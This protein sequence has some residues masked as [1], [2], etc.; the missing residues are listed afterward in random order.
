[1][2]LVPCGNQARMMISSP[3]SFVIPKSQWVEQLLP[4]LGYG[5]LQVIEVKIS[6]GVLAVGIPKAVGENRQPRT[7]LLDDDWEKA[8]AHYRICS[9][10]FSIYG[11][12]SSSPVQDLA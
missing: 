6:S 4:Q 1:M 9:K 7:Y 12:F 10:P 8:V 11:Q 2:P 5:S 3:L